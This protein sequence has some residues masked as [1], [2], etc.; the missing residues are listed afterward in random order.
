MVGLF[1]SG[2]VMAFGMSVSL[3]LWAGSAF[4][5][6]VERETSVTGPRGATRTTDTVRGP[7]VFDRSSTV[8]GPRGNSVTK[9]FDSTRGPGGLNRFSSV[10]GPRGGS[11]ARDT[12]IQR[13]P[14]AGGNPGFG[15]GFGP[16]PGPFFGPPVIVGGGGGNGLLGLGLGAAIGTGTGCSSA[17]RSLPGPCL[18]HRRRRSWSPLPQRSWGSRQPSLSID[19]V[20]TP[21]PT[22]RDG[23]RAGMKTAGWMD[24]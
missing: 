19:R 21:S 14:F 6:T 2:V 18:S 24:A 11:I 4:G 7:G 16:R 5:Q 8:T 9:Q 20:S 17:R 3:G 12:V 22:R 13:S 10:T 23:S 1:K 15:R